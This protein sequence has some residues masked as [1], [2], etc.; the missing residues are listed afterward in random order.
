MRHLMQKT[1]AL[2]FISGEAHAVM[3]ESATFF[4]NLF[5]PTNPVVMPVGSGWRL[6]NF[7]ISQT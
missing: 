7:V 1:F 2:I 4:A 6:K 5:V 3:R